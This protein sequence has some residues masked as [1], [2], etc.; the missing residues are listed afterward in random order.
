MDSTVILRTA[1]FV[2]MTENAYQDPWMRVVPYR[3]HLRLEESGY[4]N[5]NPQ[6]CG[7]LSACRERLQTFSRERMRRDG[8][9]H[10]AML[11]VFAMLDSMSITIS[12]LVGCWRP[13][14][15]FQSHP[16]RYQES[17]LASGMGS[18]GETSSNRAVLAERGLA[19]SAVASHLF[20]GVP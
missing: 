9:R 10:P 15:Y 14:R 17:T 12:I 1:N 3:L 8:Q 2:P 7:L 18:I 5:G 20:P 16:C 4:G 11:M 19:C 6:A 13:V